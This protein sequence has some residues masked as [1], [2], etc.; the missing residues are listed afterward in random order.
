MLDKRMNQRIHGDTLNTAFR[1][2]HDSISEVWKD[3]ASLRHF[4]ERGN[5]IE[6]LSN[7]AEI[8]TLHEIKSL[9]CSGREQ[10]ILKAAGLL[11]IIYQVI[12]SVAYADLPDQE[13]D[14]TLSDFIPNSLISPEKILEQSIQIFKKSLRPN[15]SKI[16]GLENR[17]SKLHKA[18]N[19][20]LV[21]VSVWLYLGEQEKVGEFYEEAINCISSYYDTKRDIVIA[22]NPLSNPRGI[23]Q[24]SRSDDFILEVRKE[25]FPRVVQ[26]CN[27]CQKG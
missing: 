20:A 24:Y 10:D 14:F 11:A 1:I 7:L 4:F 2:G 12:R 22:Q 9:C 6:V 15:R 19:V 17:L 25:L 18:Y 5:Y 3:K 27:L 23:E 13:S 26:C 21:N 8:R 16:E